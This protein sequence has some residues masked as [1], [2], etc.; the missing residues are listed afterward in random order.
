VPRGRYAQYTAAERALIGRYAVRHGNA[1]AV[2]HFT[3]TLGRDISESSVRGMRDKYL[4][5]LPSVVFFLILK[6]ESLPNMVM[7]NLV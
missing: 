2:R 3:R 7:S 4:G 1:A 5:N 6:S